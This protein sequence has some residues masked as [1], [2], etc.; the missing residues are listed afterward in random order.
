MA[1]I[2]VNKC[3]WTFAQ[4]MAGILHGSVQNSRRIFR[5][6]KRLSINE[7][8]VSDFRWILDVFTTLLWAP[9]VFICNAKTYV[10]HCKQTIPNYTMISAVNKVEVTRQDSDSVAVSATCII[11]TRRHTNG[12]LHHIFHNTVWCRYNAVNFLPN[13]QNYT[14]SLAR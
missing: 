3:I 6:G 4:S 11:N 12:Q 1:P 10:M 9:N 7:I 2:S 14:P 5:L 13:P 8:W